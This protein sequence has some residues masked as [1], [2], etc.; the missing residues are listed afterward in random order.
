M[1]KDNGVRIRAASTGWA[2]SPSPSASSR[3]S[4]AS[5]T[6]SS[7]MAGTRWAGPTP[8][9]SCGVRAASSSS[10]RSSS[11]DEGRE[12]D[13][14]A[15]PLPYPGLH[16]RH[17]RLAAVGARAWWPPVHADHLACRGSGCPSTATT[18]RRRR[19]GRGST[20]SPSPS[21]SCSRGRPRGS[22]PTATGHAAIATIGLIG[23]GIC[24]LLLETLPMNFNYWPFA[25]IV[26]FFSIFSGMFFSPNQMAVMNSLRGGAARCRRRDERHLMN[27]PG[28][29]DRCVLSIV[30]LG[31]A[32]SLPANSSTA[33]SL[34]GCRTRRP[35]SSRT[36]RPREPLRGVPRF[37][38]H[39]DRGAPSGPGFTWATPVP[40]T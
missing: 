6:G 18:S 16:H 9:S 38:P 27:S 11:S 31:L 33:C 2:T 4:P 8:A 26:L 30:T 12:P 21:A 39:P 25:V 7:P 22:S 13:V 3:S 36:C 35:R 29:L 14:P 19:C 37:Q 5:S 28:A 24:Y 32:A 20:S 17:H 23:A 10:S 15:P 34:K 40:S 1:L